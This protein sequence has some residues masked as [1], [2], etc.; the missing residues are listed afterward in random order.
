MDRVTESDC[1][2]GYHGLVLKPM[3]LVRS[4]PVPGRWHAGMLAGQDQHLIKA[5]ERLKRVSGPNGPFFRD[6][7]GR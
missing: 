2:T 6:A 7:A 5:Q 4:K 1:S 3:Y